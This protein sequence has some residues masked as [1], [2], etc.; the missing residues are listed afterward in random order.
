MYC[1][2]AQ[3][4]LRITQA[5]IFSHVAGRLEGQRVGALETYG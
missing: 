3:T 5:A 1:N 2:I 4:Y